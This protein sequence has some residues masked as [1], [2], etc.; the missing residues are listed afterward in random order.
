MFK[1][2]LTPVGGSLSLSFIAA[3]LPV[4]VVFVLLG[5]V[6]SPAWRGS[7]AGMIING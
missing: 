6:R 5:I 2:L 3:A 1:Q 4:A 7:L